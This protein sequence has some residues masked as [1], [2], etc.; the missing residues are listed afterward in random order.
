MFSAL[1]RNM[2]SAQF[3]KKMKVFRKS[4]WIN[5]MKNLET[6]SPMIDKN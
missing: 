4:V 3:I 6:L 1:S 5:G 2:S